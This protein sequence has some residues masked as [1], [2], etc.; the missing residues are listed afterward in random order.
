MYPGFSFNIIH[1]NKNSKARLGHLITPHGAIETPNFIFCATKASIKSASP[2]DLL[3]ENT[4]IILAN[5]YHLMIQPG[6]DYIARRGGLHKFMGWNGPMLTDSGGF[7]I[8]SLGYGSVASEIK[9]KAQHDRPVTLIKISEEGAIFRSYW[10]G[11][12]Q[13]LT[14]ESSIDIQCKLG[15]DLILVL[16]E[17]TPFHVDRAYTAKSLALS[18]RWALRSLKQFEIMQETKPTGQALY[19][20]VQGGVYED[21]RLEAADFLNNHPFF[22]H[23]VGGSLGGD[24]TQM[25]EVVGFAMK[26]L[27]RQRPVHLLGIGGIA[28]IFYGVKMGIDTFD[29]VIPT[30]LARHGNALVKRQNQERMNLRN[31]WCAEDDTP[32]DPECGCYCCQNFSKAYLHHLFKVKELL[33]MSLVTFHNIHF[34]NHLMADIRWGI[35]NEKLDDIQQKWIL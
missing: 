27:D 16:D 21:L 17:C 28:D 34:M 26:N 25:R 31:A 33:G 15:A 30:R 19:G 7:Q 23:A 14:P 3:R 5:T 6:A 29:C 13:I 10:D 22:G 11:S 9:G 12:K 4:Q 20:I 18:H 32:I 35:E 1:E 8:F 24:I 2:A